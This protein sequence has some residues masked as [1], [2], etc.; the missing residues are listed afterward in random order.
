[1]SVLYFSVGMVGLASAFSIPFLIRRMRRRWVYTIG[2]GCLVLTALG[3][4]TGTFAGLAVGMLARSFGGAAASITLSLYVMDYIRRRDLV[5]SEPLRIMFSALAWT[6]GPT[7]GVYLHEAVG[8]GAAELLSAA[9]ALLLIAYFWLLRLSENPAVAAATRPPPTPWGGIRRFMAQPRLRLAWVIPFSRSCW[10]TMFMVYPPLYLVQE[11]LPELAGAALV[12][13]GNA[14]LILTPLAGRLARRVG[15]RWPIIGAFLLTSVCTLGA[16]ALSGFPLAV[17]LLLLVGAIGPTVLDALGNIP[18]MRSVRPFERPQ[19][20]TVFRTHI[21]LSDLLPAGIYALLLS[22]FDL[23]AV[24][25]ACG[26]WML[27]AAAFARLLPRR[28]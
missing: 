21:D 25:L 7:L 6:A 13:A 4:W 3:L 8:L 2:A 15:L 17:I 18:F 1:M 14:L 23:D 16:G 9:S 24:F 26:L 22:F 28:F 5:H 20:T 27:A 10:W 11:G 12:S 19:M